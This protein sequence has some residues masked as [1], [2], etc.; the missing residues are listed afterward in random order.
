[1]CII[2]VFW[3]SLFYFRYLSWGHPVDISLILSPFPLLRTLSLK[4]VTLPITVAARF[5]ARTV[6]ARSNIGIVCSNPTQDMNVCV[7]VVLSADSGLAMGSSPV[8][9]VPPTV[10]KIKKLKSGQSPTEGYRNHRQIDPSTRIP[11]R[12]LKLSNT[13][14]M[15][16]QWGSTYSAPVGR[17]II[18][19]DV[20]AKFQLESLITTF[21]LSSRD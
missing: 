13:W 15:M 12:Y 11:F 20:N 4:W 14:F 5:E 6:F 10:R 2:N 17:T 16:R 9:G 21:I 3:V 7:C 18:R 1:M 8:Q 19:T